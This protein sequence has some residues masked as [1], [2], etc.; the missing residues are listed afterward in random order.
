MYQNRW[1]LARFRWSGQGSTL[2]MKM[3]MMAGGDGTDDGVDADDDDADDDA[4]EYGDGYADDEEEDGTY[5][6]D[7]G[8][9]ILR[10]STPVLAP[11]GA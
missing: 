2:M 7:A 3:M 9:V 10:G 11:A 8:D 4:D 6:D 5:D 1:C